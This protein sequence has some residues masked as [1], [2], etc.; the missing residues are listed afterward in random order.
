MPNYSSSFSVNLNVI[1]TTNRN[2]N[3]WKRRAQC[4]TYCQ[5]LRVHSYHS[6]IPLSHN[7]Q[8]NKPQS[9]TD[10][11]KPGLSSS[12]TWLSSL[13]HTLICSHLSSPL[14]KLSKSFGRKRQHGTDI[15]NKKWNSILRKSKMPLNI[16]LSMKH[17]NIGTKTTE[18][19]LK[20]G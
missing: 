10:S 3:I 16:T 5:L 6:R 7:C 14:Q 13:Q 19:Q 8:R 2:T 17:W 9:V 18:V 1:M 15:K 20:L 4:K 12:S 11:E